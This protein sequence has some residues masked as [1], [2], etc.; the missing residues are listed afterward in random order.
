[1][2]NVI[3]YSKLI[4]QKITIKNYRR[5]YG[6]NEILFSNDSNRTM[7]IIQGDMG[8]GKTTILDAINWCLY[9]EESERTRKKDNEEPIINSNAYKVLKKDET[10]ETV[11]E[12]TFSDD[13]G[14]YI[15]IER[16]VVFT[17]ESDVETEL[18]N[19][20]LV[21]GKIPKGIK[22]K[23]E[24]SLIERKRDT[25]LGSPIMYQDPIHDESKINTKVEE[26]FPKSLSMFFLFDAE[27]LDKFFEVKNN[28]VKKGIENITGLPILQEIAKT[29]KKI[30]SDQTQTSQLDPILKTKLDEIEICNKNIQ[31]FSEELEKVENELE[32][33]NLEIQGIEFKLNKIG[34][35]EYTERKGKQKVLEVQMET[36]NDEIKNVGEL[37]KEKVSKS[38]P[39]MLLKE[40]LEQA[41]KL[42]QIDE[43]NGELPAPVNPKTLKDMIRTEDCICE[44]KLQPA[45]L[46]K[47]KKMLGLSEDSALVR[48]IGTG[49]TIISNL[50]QTHAA[51]LVQISMDEDRVQ[52][53]DLQDEYNNMKR[54]W[55]KIEDEIG[56]ISEKEVTDLRSKRNNISNIK[57]A[58][59][60]R[61][62][63]SIAS[64]LKVAKTTLEDLENEKE[65]LQKKKIGL[66]KEYRKQKIARFVSKE[67]ERLRLG[68]IEDIRLEAEKQTSKYFLDLVNPE[69]F[70]SVSID[71]EYNTRPVGHDGVAAGYSVGQ[72]VAM[73]LAFIAALREI[74]GKKY[75][76]LMDSGYHS[77]SAPERLELAQG[78]AKYLKGTQITCLVQGQEYTSTSRKDISGD[79]VGTVQDEL[80][81]LNILD[82]EYILKEESPKQPG[83]KTYAK[84]ELHK[85]YRSV[86]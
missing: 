39:T 23:S 51:D 20:P 7:T 70:K 5:F 33:N 76:L 2:K 69:D 56:E 55:Q 29:F 4:L 27:T 60:N 72:G 24:I 65:E 73:A 74:T 25:S 78:F 46:E 77:V 42:F 61:D 47:F 28:L 9:N 37:L 81:K 22:V 15:T 12:I 3:E 6:E 43:D 86:S 75:F 32:Q 35:E 30:Q 13:I 84:V 80:K 40:T 71:A 58:A 64:K 41:E 66:T 10:D 38:L 85:N 21:S 63:G 82:R 11:V 59:L 62:I 57:N 54:E 36:N 31:N 45:M 53:S 83:L 26:F 67:A 50:L 18:H 49:R 68:L 8:K 1:M 17:K 79:T 16:K 34:G 48:N 52:R 44:R 14:P 19:V